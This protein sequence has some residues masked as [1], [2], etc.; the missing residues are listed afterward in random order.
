[1]LSAS[2]SGCIPRISNYTPAVLS[3]LSWVS[4]FLGFHT[5]GVFSHNDTVVAFAEPDKQLILEPFFCLLF[6][7]TSVVPSFPIGAGDVYAHH[8]IALSLHVTVLSLLKGALDS[9]GSKLMPDKY[10]FPIGFACD[11]PTRGGTCDISAWDSSYLAA[12]WALNADA[13][14]MFY[15]HWRQLVAFENTQFQ[16]DDSATYLNGWFRDYL[17]FNSAA[18][19]NGYTSFRATDLTA[20]AWVFLAAHLLWATGFMFLLSW[21]G[22]WQELI[23][24]IILLHLKTPILFN[25]FAHSTSA[26][27]ALS[28]VQARFIGLSHFSSGFIFTYAAFVLASTT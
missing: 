2:A 22:Y 12:F 21:R 26:P 25:L 9:R 28:I 24:I 1:V 17:W 4:L 7:G 23:D 27:V 10:V 16:Y 13:W 19:I 18:L 5:L 6:G 20:W 3:H 14:L 8:A 11:G 15:F